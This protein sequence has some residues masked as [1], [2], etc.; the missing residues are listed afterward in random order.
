MSSDLPT[1]EVTSDSFPTANLS[2]MDRLAAAM[3]RLADVQERALIQHEKEQMLLEREAQLTDRYAVMNTPDL[4]T[5]MKSLMDF[6]NN[7]SQVN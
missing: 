1:D 3:N 2:P 6:L 5:E 4:P 7:Y